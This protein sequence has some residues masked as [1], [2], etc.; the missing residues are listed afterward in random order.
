MQ[1]C[2]LTSRSSASTANVAIENEL[3]RKN[4]SVSRHSVSSLPF[5]LEDE[6]RHGVAIGLIVLASDQTIEAEF[7]A[8]T[9]TDEVAVYQ[10][11]IANENRITPET[12]GAM[13]AGLT[14]STEVILPGMPLDVVAFGCTSASMVIGEQRVFEHIRQAR[15][16]VACTTPVTAA[17]A[18]FDALKV[19]RLALITPYGD[20]VNRTIRAYLA[21][22]DIETPVVG[23]FH[24]RDD[25][26]VARISQAS[27][28]E[29][30]LALGEKE[31][32]EGVFISC[33]A[34]RAAGLVPRLEAA[35]GKPVT[36]SN[37]ALAWHCLRL[38]GIQDRACDRGRLF[39]QGLAGEEQY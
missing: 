38:A 14:A 33:T 34:L 3:I 15:P 11:R 29:A 22:R 9:A 7:R 17:L 36:A 16:A 13:E 19:K 37:H 18:A 8:L 27:I 30:A 23:S 28:E 26:R 10:S 32:V 21:D 5:N 6:G 20:D 12:L 35:L 2:L 31:E 24:E 39:G 1:A 4:Q 25:R